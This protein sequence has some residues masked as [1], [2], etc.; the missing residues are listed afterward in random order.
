MSVPTTLVQSLLDEVQTALGQFAPHLR[1]TA[2]TVRPLVVRLAEDAIR[3]VDNVVRA[4][5]ITR[6]AT[7]IGSVLGGAAATAL[8][9]SIGGPFGSLL[10][11]PVG[12]SIGSAIGTGLGSAF[13]AVLDDFLRSHETPAPAHAPA[14]A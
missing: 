4:G 11:A 14:T 13:S 7:T 5:L 1:L 10:S 8:A 2:E 6:A 12:S 3:E 9:A